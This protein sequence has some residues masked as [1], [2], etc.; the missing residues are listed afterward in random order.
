M[1]DREKWDS[2]IPGRIFE[3]IAWLI[4]SIFIMM[5]NLTNMPTEPAPQEVL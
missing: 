4:L 2:S 3:K 1:F 5:E